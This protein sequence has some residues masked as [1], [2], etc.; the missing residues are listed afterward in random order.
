MGYRV[1]F[2]L[3]H[4]P[5]RKSS[6]SF[7]QHSCQLPARVTTQK[8]LVVLHF[9]TTEALK[10]SAVPDLHFEGE[11]RTDTKRTNSLRRRNAIDWRQHPSVARDEGYT[12]LTAWVVGDHLACRWRINSSVKG[13]SSEVL[14][15]TSPL[16]LSFLPLFPIPPVLFCI[17]FYHPFFHVLSASHYSLIL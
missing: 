7:C 2:E 14:T 6:S 16:P 13:S 3:L 4:R 5:N 12:F 8:L 9:N 15:S 17:H 1:K 11:R 10:S